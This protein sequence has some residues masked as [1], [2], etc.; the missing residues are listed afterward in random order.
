LNGFWRTAFDFGASD[1]ALS[2]EQIARSK[3]GVLLALT[4]A[5][6]VVLAYHGEGLPRSW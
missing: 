5:G 2:D 3:H 6:M 1:R 4:A